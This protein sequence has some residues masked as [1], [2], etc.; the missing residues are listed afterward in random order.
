VKGADKD[1]RKQ[2]PEPESTLS[3]RDVKKE[4]REVEEERKTNGEERR[5]RGEKGKRS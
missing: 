3:A 2:N 1:T 4:L 5:R